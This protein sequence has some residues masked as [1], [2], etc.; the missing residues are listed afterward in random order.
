MMSGHSVDLTP[1]ATRDVR[2]ITRV[3]ESEWGEDQA[4]IYLGK[5]YAA[6]E[7]IGMFPEMGRRRDD[8]YRGL[9]ATTME[10][11]VIFYEIHADHVLVVRVLHQRMDAR[12][13]LPG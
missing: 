2:D 10:S 12:S 3:S 6:C 5:I 1:N 9:R 8:I 4:R 11:H 13:E 7:H